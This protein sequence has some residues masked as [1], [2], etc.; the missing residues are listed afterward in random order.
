MRYFIN[1]QNNNKKNFKMQIRTGNKMSVFLNFHSI[2][3]PT[4]RV[5]ACFSR[6]PPFGFRVFFVSFLLQDERSR[7]GS[8]HVRLQKLR[9]RMEREAALR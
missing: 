5:F 3:G 6:F 9:R 2:K 8:F 1:E 7:N 4:I